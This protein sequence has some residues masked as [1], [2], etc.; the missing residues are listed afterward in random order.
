MS[1]SKGVR[2]CLESGLEAD[3]LQSGQGWYLDFMSTMDALTFLM[4]SGRKIDRTMD[5]MSTF[6]S[7]LEALKDRTECGLKVP[8][9]LDWFRIGSGPYVDFI[10]VSRPH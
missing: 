6:S 2:I 10:G 5:A 4:K 1:V 7:T 8:L 3:G 9:T